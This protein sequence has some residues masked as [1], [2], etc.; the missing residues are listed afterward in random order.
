MKV[1][2]M[3]MFYQMKTKDIVQSSKWFT[4]IL[5]FQSLYQF[6][7]QENQV[8]MDHLRLADYQ[9]LMLIAAEAF[10]VGDGAILNVAMNDLQNIAQKIPT[11]WIVEP[12]M[13]KPWNALEMTIKDPNGYLFTLTEAIRKNESD[14]QTLMDQAKDYF[15]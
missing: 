10:T 8:M 3:P 2:V 5:G 12:L 4:E 7:N 9:D 14:F 15:Q 11:K 6:R 13:E 1:Y